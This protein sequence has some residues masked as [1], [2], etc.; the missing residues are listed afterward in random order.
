MTDLLYMDD[1]YLRKWN[2]QVKRAE[3]NKIV[4]D[5]TAFYPQGGGQPSDSG[6]VT[7]E[8]KTFRILDV[9]KEGSDI[10]HEVDQQGLSSG[11]EVTCEL[12]WDRRYTLMRM[13]T[14]AHLLSALINTKTGAMITG[15]QLGTEKS[16]IDFNL[17]DYSPELMRG[18]VEEANKRIKQGAEVKWYYLP[19]KE[20]LKIP[21]IVKLA[22][23]LPPTIST[24]RIV[25][26]EGIDK[27]ADGGTHVKNITEIGKVAPL[28]TENKG[29][30]N[31]RLYFTL[32]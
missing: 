8:G 12:D 15:N 27:Q 13:H 26:I 9:K 32:E 29:K 25:E 3:E 7:H 1:A 31:R 6:T 20:A 23:R 2:A 17:E 11:M 24:L 22:S 16:R 5:R 10:M 14:A 4:L 21:N 18:I 30:N 28:K 19:R